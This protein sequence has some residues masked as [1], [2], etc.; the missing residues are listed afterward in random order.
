MDIKS[1]ILEFNNCRAIQFTDVTSAFYATK[2]GDQG[3]S[4]WTVNNYGWYED[5]VSPLPF[6]GSNNGYPYNTDN[7]ARMIK[8]SDVFKSA[9]GEVGKK[10]KLELKISAKTTSGKYEFDPINLYENSVKHGDL[11][12]TERYTGL[13]NLS[14]NIYATDLTIGGK[15]IGEI[16][17][18]GVYTIVYTITG[19]QG[20]NID[21][22][23]TSVVFISG[24]VRNKVYRALSR[25]PIE[26]NNVD[27]N[28]NK[29]EECL[30]AYTLLRALENSNF[31]ARQ[32]DLIN[33]LRTLEKFCLTTKCFKR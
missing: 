29:Y 19:T 22:S 9:T 26:S 20:D 12:E 21:S 3:S 23:V 25:L 10:Y 5:L 31:V 15:S 4:K 14:W 28:N 2:G 8:T 11:K 7:H 32:D 24:V 18:D 6:D 30:Y 27:L 16:I 17:P 13:V 1:S 33:G